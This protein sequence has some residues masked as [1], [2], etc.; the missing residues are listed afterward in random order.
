MT[1]LYKKQKLP[2]EFLSLK[3]LKGVLTR[4][5][6][7]ERSHSFLLNLYSLLK[8]ACRDQ[9]IGNKYHTIKFAPQKPLAIINKCLFQLMPAFV[10][11]KVIKS[12]KPFDLPV[13]I[14]D[15]HAYFKACNWLIKASLQN[16]KSAL[17]IPYLLTQEIYATLHNEGAAFGY[18]KSFIDIAID[19]QPFMR[20]IKRKRKVIS[21]SKKTYAASR[22][23]KIYRKQK[24]AS[25]RRRNHFYKNYRRVNLHSLRRQ[26]RV[27][28]KKTKLRKNFNYVI[29]KPFKKK[30]KKVTPKLKKIKRKVRK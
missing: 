15:N 11:T 19:Q 29:K 4:S 21:R 2:A 7:K 6:N 23:R 26:A 18:L 17:T 22:L 16:N 14:S 1:S 13:P 5:G 12:G 3:K 8:Q 24:S 20:F 30:I 10:F 9:V 28:K 25:Y 27:L